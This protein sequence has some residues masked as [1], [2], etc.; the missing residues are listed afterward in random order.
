[1]PEVAML[2]TQSHGFL[3]DT[4]IFLQI[5]QFDIRYILDFREGFETP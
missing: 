5:N 1:M 4:Q 3:A 2:V